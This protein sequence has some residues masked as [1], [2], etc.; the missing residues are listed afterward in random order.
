MGDF[1]FPN[2][3]PGNP[4]PQVPPRV[5]DP[6]GSG[7]A[8]PGVGPPV[9]GDV[10]PAPTGDGKPP[11]AFLGPPNVVPGRELIGPPVQTGGGYGAPVAGRPEPGVKPPPTFLGPPVPPGPAGIATQR[12][13]PPAIRPPAG[14]P[15]M[16]QGSMGSPLAG[17]GPV[18][19]V[20][21]PPNPGRQPPPYPTKYP[22]R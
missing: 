5:Q 16:R 20:R 11:Q 4:P 6:Y 22:V 1:R 15:P 12:Q 3:P 2:Q 19:P 9:E 17:G 10:W 13:A 18:P 7:R 14:P 8:G 21:Q